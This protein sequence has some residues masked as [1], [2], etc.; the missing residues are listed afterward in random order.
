MPP[1]KRLTFLTSASLPFQKPTSKQ[2]GFIT[3]AAVMLMPLSHLGK[4]KG[5][6]MQTD[7]VDVLLLCAVQ[8]EW[9]SLKSLLTSPVSDTV[10]TDP[11][12]RGRIEYSGRTMTAALVEVGMGSMPSGQATLQAVERYR[13]R[14]VVFVGIAGGIKDVR[15]G[16]VVIADKVYYYESGKLVDGT[17]QGRSDTRLVP[18]N[19][20]GIA[21]K[22]RSSFQPDKFRVFTGAIASGEKV[23]ADV[24]AD[25]LARIR[26]QCGDALALEMEGSAVLSAIDRAEVNPDYFLVRGVSDLIA[27]KSA[28]D[29][30]GGQQSASE[31]A[32]AVALKLI[33]AWDVV[34]EVSIPREQAGEDLIAAGLPIPSAAECFVLITA[35]ASA[36]ANA[37][38]VSGLPLTMVVDL[39]PLTDVRGL[40]ANVRSVLA[41]RR[42]VHLGSPSNPPSFG[43]NSTA[44]VSIRGFDNPPQT[45]PD[46]TKK[47]RRSWRSMLESFAAS[48]GGRRITALVIDDGD[49]QWDP[50]RAAIL[51][52]LMTE[53][54]DHIYV[55]I[56]GSGRSIA[57]DFRLALG[58]DALGTA[59][60]L[61]SPSPESASTR[62]L[63]GADGHVEISLED[64]AWVGEDANIYWASEPDT[65]ASNS[66]AHDFFRGGEI[67]PA[68]LA[69]DADVTRTQSAQLEKQLLGILG[70]RRTLRQNLYHA[71]GAGG[72]TLAR[73]LGFNIRTKFPVIFAE[74]FREGETV[75]RV[76][77]LGRKTKNAVLVVVDSPA[78]RDDQVSALIE[79]LQAM[80]VP[81]VV[82]AVARRYSPPSA[83]SSS[84]YLPE[85][86]DDLE[87]RDFVDAFN[88]RSDI[89][90]LALESLASYNDHR[91]NAFFFGLVAFEDDFQGLASFVSGRLL[92]VEGPQR[93]VMLVC[94]IAHYFG[95]S[96][97]PEY[98]LA[99]L[100]GLP[101][102]K[103]AGFA[104]VLAPELRGLLWRSGNGEWRTTHPLVAE[105]IL[106]QL[107][108][109]DVQWTQ[110]LA[111]WGRLF[112]DF[113]LD[114]GE[115]D[116]M[117]ELIE[118]VFI[119]RGEDPVLSNNGERGVFARL[120]ERIPSRDGASQLLTHVAERQ[121]NHAHLWAHAARYQALRMENFANAEKFAKY[122][123]DL[124][125]DS[126]TLHHI[127]GMVH[128]SRVYDGIGRR[129]ELDALEPWI[130]DAAGEF[131]IT[132]A[133]A[134]STKDHGF[135]SEIQM[136]VR[137]VEY[138]IRDSTLAAYL[139]SVAHP[140]V[141][142]CV[143]KAEDLMATL[144]YRGDPK[145]QSGFQQAE[146]AKL[147]RMYGDYAASL[148]LLDGLLKRGSVPLATVR[149]QI[150]WTYL[151]RA[152][153]DWKSLPFKEVDRIVSL[154]MENLTQEGYAS[155]DA[156]PWWRA[157]RLKKPP[158]SH[159]RV[160]EVLAYWRA[161]N[162]CLDAEYCSFVAYA[163]D[164]LAGFA[165]S[166]PEATKHARVSAE[167]ARN[168][169]TRS[170]SV[171]WLG[172]GVGMN[173]LVHHSELGRWD[174]A[175]DFW[176]DTSR[177]K[178]IEG[179]IT[180][181]HGPQAGTAE[182]AGMKAFFVPQR[183]NVTKGR[184]E[185]ERI[186]GYLA[187]T[188]DGLR[189]WEPRLV[190]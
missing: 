42:P 8:V 83:H 14:L 187:F 177:L 61:L 5:D 146:R 58:P 109:G 62:V 34:A 151:A 91:R 179:R 169:G 159:E 124:D 144:R 31:N 163:L 180:Q 85:V 9:D 105:E 166:L 1:E 50:W 178:S 89:G 176:V 53:F 72:T 33:I 136:R 116:V 80:S 96:A 99:R 10:L 2:K 35:P 149:R 98:A 188:H 130:D 12:L 93:E 60:S 143:E 186:S 39:D 57:N 147:N 88:A 140:L 162:P 71:P 25:E 56:V 19:L 52:D 81:A 150:V 7:S 27:G 172:D 86:L 78:V 122:A 65:G 170:R 107:G 76:E 141:I 100:V 161:S 126:P 185:N 145:Q 84:P 24:G 49:S 137:V 153:G 168:Q 18:A 158:T 51:D 15:I 112:A 115:D 152:Q 108:G 139:N 20:K 106:R 103:A 67:T 183:A 90:R 132:R 117:R 87:A 45:A 135:V 59:L 4:L 73:R 23:V 48:V 181:I 142:A 123:S 43:P 110:A 32:K 3:K 77:L 156:L 173:A 121:A 111:G 127:L 165:A 38:A 94:S 66:E 95:Q 189:I 134:E 120:I 157:V 125:P 68:A 70:N 29:A 92:G 113:C 13:P 16:D 63:P 190:E 11:A 148:Q 174:P 6:I 21:R 164:V 167:M 114:G 28:T 26:S 155:S 55:G 36:H 175:V 54:G 182:V 40:H 128:R 138:G 44:W 30:G 79:E 69:S 41:E 97:V 154:L 46:W 133:I 22:L 171:D 119:E 37:I 160:K 17:F 47:L 131:G 118:S 101:P 64:A 74:K 104:R 129:V 184:H 82:L 75:R 102:S